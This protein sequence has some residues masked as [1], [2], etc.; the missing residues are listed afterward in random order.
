MEHEKNELY[1]AFAQLRKRILDPSLSKERRKKLVIKFLQ[2]IIRT[3]DGSEF[4]RYIGLYGPPLLEK[5][6]D[7]DTIVREFLKILQTAR[8]LD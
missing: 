7:G 5:E 2:E 3:D 1:K 6:T 4:S 8:Q